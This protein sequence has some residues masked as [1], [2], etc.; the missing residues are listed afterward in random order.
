[1]VQTLEIS[2]ER[3]RAGMA[4]SGSRVWRETF[5]FL[6]IVVALLAL[7]GASAQLILSQRGAAIDRARAQIQIAA[8]ISAEL[9]TARQRSSA[10]SETAASI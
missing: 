6:P 10:Q 4:W 3:R 2:R 8:S 5:A 7:A 9:T 1:M